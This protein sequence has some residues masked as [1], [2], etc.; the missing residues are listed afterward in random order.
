MP[1]AHP[2]PLAAPLGEFLQRWRAAL[3]I[4]S[5]RASGHEQTL[6]QQRT[7]LGRGPGADLAFPDA[8][9]A[10]A[11]ACIEYDQGRFV[12]RHLS[13]HSQTLLNGGAVTES[14][15]KDGDSLELG[16]YRFQFVLES[17]DPD[18]TRAAQR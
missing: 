5:G 18:R 9:M 17:R 12:L 14:V 8:E 4:L 6:D 2:A 10:R 1:E 7:V 15:L 11:H 13:E 3:V 16:D